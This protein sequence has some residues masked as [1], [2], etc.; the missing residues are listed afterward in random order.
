MSTKKAA[1]T[2]TQSTTPAGI[3]GYLVTKT[4]QSSTASSA[5]SSKR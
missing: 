4:Q 3:S 1:T 2:R 5:K